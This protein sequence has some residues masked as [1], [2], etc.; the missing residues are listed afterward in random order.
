[1]RLPAISRAAW[2]A[3]HCLRRTLDAGFGGDDGPRRR[4][5]RRMTELHAR[6]QVLTI[7]C[8]DFSVYRRNDRRVIDFVSPG[9]G[10]ED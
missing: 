5:D 1:M 6:S 7:D 4:I 9:K 8:G 10:R 2:L 3:V